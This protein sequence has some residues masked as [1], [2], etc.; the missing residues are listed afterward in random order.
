MDK[1][2]II[3][4]VGKI[5]L[6]L[7]GPLGSIMEEMMYGYGSRVRAKRLT[8]FFEKLKGYLE[9]K[10][11]TQFIEKLSNEDFYDVFE[12]VI[13]KASK[14]RSE[15][16]LNRLRDIVIKQIENPVPDIDKTEIFIELVDQTTEVELKIMMAY[17]EYYALMG[18]YNFNLMAADNEL[19]RL[20][21][22]LKREK[23]LKDTGKANNYNW[24]SDR[25]HDMA[26]RKL[27]TIKTIDELKKTLDFKA[28]GIDS[29]T[30]VYYKQSLI[31]KG[32]MYDNGVGK[33][34]YEPLFL[35]ILTELSGE[36]MEYLKDAENISKKFNEVPVE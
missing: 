20:A 12:S 29:S 17:Q 15:Y 22:A 32:L 34:D 26:N 31:S 13:K 25:F 10:S 30:F 28:F 18:S 11:D 3:D 35:L 8:N 27:K 24:T 5:S 7:L 14:T 2:E 36:F 9:T 21:E 23:I 4:S 19:S 33:N 16:K 1:K 6:K